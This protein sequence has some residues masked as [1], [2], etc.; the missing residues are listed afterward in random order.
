MTYECSVPENV[1][2]ELLQ[3]T[4]SENGIL[5]IEAP[6]IEQSKTTNININRE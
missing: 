2:I 6:I 5:S 4:L 1:E 3:S